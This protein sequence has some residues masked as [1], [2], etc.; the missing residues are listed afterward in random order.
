MLRSKK[1]LSDALCYRIAL[2]CALGLAHLH[3]RRFIHRDI[4]SPNILIT[5]DFH[6]KLGDFGS[7]KNITTTLATLAPSASASAQAP[8]PVAPSAAAATSL[9]WTAP[10]LLRPPGKAFPASDVFSFGMLLYE[11]VTRNFVFHVFTDVAGCRR[12]ICRMGRCPILRFAIS[13]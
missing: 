8:T 9:R 13:C 6:A 11:I 12:T 2:E 3:A 1:D 7:V 5:A 10:E 4:K